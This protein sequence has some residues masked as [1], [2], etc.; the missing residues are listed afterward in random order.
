MVTMGALMDVLLGFVGGE[1]SIAKWECFG[2]VGSLFWLH[3]QNDHYL[4]AL[5]GP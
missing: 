3:S 1:C 5:Y 2:L 4:Q